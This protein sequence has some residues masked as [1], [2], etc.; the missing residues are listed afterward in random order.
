MRRFCRPICHRKNY[1]V[2]FLDKHCYQLIPIA[3][4][5]FM[6]VEAGKDLREGVVQIYELLP[7]P[8]VQENDYR[9]S[10][11]GDLKYRESSV[12][13]LFNLERSRGGLIRDGGA[14]SQSQMTRMYLIAFQLFASYFADSTYD[15]TSHIHRFDTFYIPNTIKFNM[16][17]C[18]T[19]YMKDRW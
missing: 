18:L 12:K 14:Y 8:L 1:F 11:D 16:Q 9:F 17:A 6:R 2:T 7:S 3:A 5:K 13:C 10:C 4:C 15:L 19:N